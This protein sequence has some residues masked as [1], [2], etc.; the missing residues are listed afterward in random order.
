MSKQDERLLTVRMSASAY[1]RAQAFAKK[2]G[3]TLSDL[4]RELLEAVIG[5]KRL[6]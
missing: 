4:V 2:M 5:G 1:A 3:T 6:R